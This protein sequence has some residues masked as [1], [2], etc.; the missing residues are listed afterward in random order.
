[1]VMT[2]NAGA[3]PAD[4]WAQDAAVGG[5]RIVGEA[6][7]FVDLLR[8]L[9]DAPITGH[10]ADVMTAATMDT[11]SLSLR[12]VDGSIGTIHYFSNGNKALSKERLEVFS[13][14]RILQL[15]NYLSLKGI[16]WKG[17]RSEK[18][19]RQDKGQLAC[20]SA[21]LKAIQNGEPA[22]I[23]L[24]EVLEVARVSIALTEGGNGR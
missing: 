23:P 9:A 13:G 20:A 22:P 2:V 21:F 12:F 15:D 11:A 19:W 14:G 6:C 3:I 24:A 5:G 4:H 18:S 1:M 16:G 7:H 17:L 10:H 8:H